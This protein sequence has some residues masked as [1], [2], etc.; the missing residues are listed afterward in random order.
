[1]KHA[2]SLGGFYT[3]MR[4]A[5]HGTRKGTVVVNAD[6][7]KALD[8]LG[9]DWEIKNASFKDRIED[10]K[11]FKAKHGHVRVTVKQDKSLSTFCSNM[12]SALRTGTMIEDRI[13]LLGELGFTWGT[14]AS[15]S[16]NT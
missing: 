12:R 9:F 14:R 4:S 6:R 7:I 15:Y 8:E 5:R 11:A 1:V 16:K 3:Y 13:K 10:L 2:K